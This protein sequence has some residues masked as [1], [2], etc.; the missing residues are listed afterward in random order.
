MAIK[1]FLASN[2][3]KKQPD[4]TMESK[5]MHAQDYNILHGTQPMSKVCVQKIFALLIT[6]LILNIILKITQPSW[7]ITI[8]VLCF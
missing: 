7:K 2:L 1:V 8:D 5:K 4:Y 6:W 3:S